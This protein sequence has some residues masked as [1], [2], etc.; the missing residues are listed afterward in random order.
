MIVVF[1]FRSRRGSGSP[2][3]SLTLFIQQHSSV[4]YTSGAVVVNRGQTVSPVPVTGLPPHNWVTIWVTGV[5]SG[6]NQVE[7]G[8]TV[9]LL[10]L[11]TSDLQTTTLTYSHTL[12]TRSGI[13]LML[14]VVIESQQILS[15]IDLYLNFVNHYAF[16]E[17][18]L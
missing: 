10:G 1:D 5:R 3:A 17:F 2:R 14:F 7:L 13:Y 8:R 6:S 12:M 16:S 15:S 18:P 4:V 11:N 9:V